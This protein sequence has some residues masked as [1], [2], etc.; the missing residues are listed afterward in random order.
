MHV[1]S[2]LDLVLPHQPRVMLVGKMLLFVT[3]TEETPCF[4]HFPIKQALL[5]AKGKENTNS[6]ACSQ[7][8]S[9]Q[10]SLGFHVL[11]QVL[12]VFSLSFCKVAAWVT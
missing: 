8:R 11:F 3:A 5:G 7:I 6:T 1:T 2:S 12:N 4:F 9:L 10:S